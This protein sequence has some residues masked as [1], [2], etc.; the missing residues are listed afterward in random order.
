VPPQRPCGSRGFRACS[1]TPA[2]PASG[3]KRR[4]K[5]PCG[6]EVSEL[7]RERQ[8]S[9]PPARSGGG[10]GALRGR[11]LRACSGTPAK[12]ASGG[13]RR[14]RGSPLRS[15]G[16]LPPHD[17][18]VLGA[19]AAALRVERFP[20]LLGNAGEAGLR[21]EAAGKRSPAGREV[22]ELARERRRSRPPARSGGK[23]SPAGREVSELARERRRSRPPVRSGGK[24][25]SG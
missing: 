17:L 22:S 23:R 9:R 19:S 20:S 14:G 25:S 16:A 12:P 10:K 11:G 18:E 1:G 8:R 6:G 5:E 2:K 4:E 21:R 15:K 3:A 24:R 13:K 7:A